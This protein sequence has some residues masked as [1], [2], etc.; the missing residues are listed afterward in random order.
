MVQF[1]EIEDINVQLNPIR[2]SLKL[3][4]SLRRAYG[5]DCDKESRCFYF[6]KD[7][8]IFKAS[9][10]GSSP[11][12]KDQISFLQ[13][14]QE[15]LKDRAL[16]LKLKEAKEILKALNI[17]EIDYFLIPQNTVGEFWIKTKD[18]FYIY[19]DKTVDIKTQLLG[20]KELFNKFDKNK[21]FEYIDLRV[22]DR[23]YYR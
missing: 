2:N 8:F 11:I 4:V 16:F 22:T 15:G 18:G 17:V 20:M 9:D 3:R 5:T 21:K 1:P 10:N 14:G 13:I 19:L 12:I 23:I 7:G 6:D